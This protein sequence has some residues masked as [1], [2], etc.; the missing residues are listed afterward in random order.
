MILLDFKCSIL[1]FIMKVSST[2][3]NEK[4]GKFVFCFRLAPVTMVT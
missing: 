2:I 4:K 1:Y 3:Q